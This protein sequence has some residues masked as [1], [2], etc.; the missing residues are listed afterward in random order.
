MRRT[1]LK[2]VLTLLMPLLLLAFSP[3]RMMLCEKGMTACSECC[4]KLIQGDISSPELSSQ[5]LCCVIYPSQAATA[6]NVAPQ[7]TN[8]FSKIQFHSKGVLTNSSILSLSIYARSDKV[9]SNGFIY[10]N[11]PLFLSKQSLLV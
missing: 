6:I 11:L 5:N 9:L 10:P 7:K 2:Y 1:S 8:D 4:H 3:I